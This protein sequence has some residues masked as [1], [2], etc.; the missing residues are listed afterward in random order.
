MEKFL[1]SQC[2]Y[3]K[4]QL[5]SSFDRKNIVIGMILEKERNCVLNCSIGMNGGDHLSL[6][7]WKPLPGKYRRYPQ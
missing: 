6:D 1:V 4:N 5:G 3:E 7:K 2:S